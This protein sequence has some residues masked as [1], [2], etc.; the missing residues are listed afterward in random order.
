MRYL[1]KAELQVSKEGQRAN[2]TLR[3]TQRFILES[4]MD[5]IQ[6]IILTQP[7][8][9]PTLSRLKKNLSS[10]T[11]WLINYN[12]CLCVLFNLVLFSVL[13]LNN[14]K[15]T[16]VEPSI[17][18]SESSLFSSAS[19]YNRQKHLSKT[20]LVERYKNIIL[21]SVEFIFAL[22]MSNIYKIISCYCNKKINVF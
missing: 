21:R 4:G 6:D 15:D 12:F 22:S 8:L 2:T 14:L 10:G 3:E 11:T 17:S 5:T 1:Q 20:E 16:N 7:H 18:N 13:S 9:I 19:N